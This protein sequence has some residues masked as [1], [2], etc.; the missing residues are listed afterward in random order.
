[1]NTVEPVSR[2]A[3][4]QGIIRRSFSM[5]SLPWVLGAAPV[6]WLLIECIRAHAVRRG[7][8]DH[9]VARSAHTRPVPRLAGVAIVVVLAAGMTIAVRSGL[10][11]EALLAAVGIS[12]MVGV[13]G[14]LD[15]FLNLPSTPRLLTHVAAAAATVWCYGPIDRVGLGG[16]MISLGVL[17]VPLTVLW[18]CWF[19]NAFNFMDGIDGI[20]G[21]QTLVAGLLWM[22]LG[23][24]GD[25]TALWPGALLAAAS[26][27]FLVHNWSPARVFLG[28][29]GATT[30]GYWLATLPLLDSAPSHATLGLLVLWP[31]VFDATAT[32]ARRIAAREPLN[33]GHRQHYYQ[34]L[35]RTGLRHSLVTLLFGGL[36]ALCAAIGGVTHVY[37][38]GMVIAIVSMAACGVGLALVVRQRERPA[39]AMA[40]PGFTLRAPIAS[41]RE[42]AP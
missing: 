26:L 19:I 1:M 15:D 17:A 25:G 27:G 33:Q 11:P 29:A 37:D 16:D 39:R 42:D 28:D 38:F 21:V 10:A 41:V 5:R 24:A 12:L 2:K 22:T 31:F 9:P 4:R 7:W 3:A 8:L 13:V 23:V 6:T 18:I 40:A 32:L 14:L 35:T 34:R 36:A 20:A 30:V